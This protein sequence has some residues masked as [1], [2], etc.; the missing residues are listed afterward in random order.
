MYY[1]QPGVGVLAV[2]G[3][4]VLTITLIG[5]KDPPLVHSGVLVEAN[6]ASVGTASDRLPTTD[7]VRRHRGIFDLGQ[8]STF[9][10]SV[11]SDPNKLAKFNSV[12]G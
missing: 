5:H 1:L 9:F 10:G 2:D 12:T 3:V 11:T 7:N 4:L 8:E 6:T